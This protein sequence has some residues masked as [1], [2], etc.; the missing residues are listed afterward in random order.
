MYFDDNLTEIIRI[1][2]VLYANGSSGYNW[3]IKQAEFSDTYPNIPKEKLYE[4]MNKKFREI[5]YEDLHL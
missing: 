5:E 4:W 3:I 1:K 2:Q